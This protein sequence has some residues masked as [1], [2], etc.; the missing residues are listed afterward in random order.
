MNELQDQPNPLD[1]SLLNP[2]DVGPRPKC[3]THWPRPMNKGDLMLPGML[4]VSVVCIYI[5]G[6]C[7]GPATASATQAPFEQQVNSVLSRL[8]DASA[9][10]L[11][12]QKVIEATRI[13]Y[14]DI[15]QQQIPLDDL[16]GNPFVFAQPTEPEPPKT[17][18]Q[19]ANISEDANRQALALSEAQRAVQQLR[20]QAVL[21]TSHGTSAII[22]DSLLS[23]G[24]MINGWTVREIHARTVVLEWNGHTHTLNMPR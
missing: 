11:Q 17:E 18:D 14:R 21:K 10:R 19:R 12:S 13:L 15:P 6:C 16:K 4:V 9:T 3:S 23:E 7:D 1:S 22:S 2:A 20:L 8:S 24:Q 5:L